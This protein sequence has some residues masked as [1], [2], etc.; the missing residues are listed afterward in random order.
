MAGKR[1]P[2]YG[3]GINDADYQTQLFETVN[4][5]QTRT[6]ACPF[7]VKWM[8]ILERCY[9]Q[10]LHKRRPTYI[11]CEISD[12]WKIFSNFKRWMIQQDWN[13]KQLDK[14]ILG[15]STLYSEATCVF[16]TSE[17]NKFLTGADAIRGKL[18][19]GVSADNKSDGFLATCCNPF[20]NKQERLG[21]FATAD[22]AHE[23][24]RAKKHQHALKYAS[25]H[26]DSRVAQVLETKFLGD[27][28]GS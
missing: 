22:T 15:D 20:T 5:K 6:W 24:W 1:R 2:I 28:S 8:G 12:D 10:A 11:G 19:I 14:D 3:V 26:S 25:Q 17:L 4:G 13:N 18:P 7:Y 16:I 23:A 9:S 27:A 21:V